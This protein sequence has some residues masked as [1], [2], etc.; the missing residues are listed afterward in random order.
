[1]ETEKITEKFVENSIIRWL[2]ERNWK[3]S[4]VTYKKHYVDIKAERNGDQY[5]VECNE[6]TA[7]PGTDFL[8]CLGQIISRMTHK[9][10][11]NYYAIGLPKKEIYYKLI[12]KNLPEI[13]RKKLKLRI[14]FVNKEG[15]VEEIKSSQKI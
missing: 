8:T 3:I 4:K 13:M 11:T 1:M 6:E 15:K 14:I 10:D 2:K 9:S 7:S 12:K 5:F